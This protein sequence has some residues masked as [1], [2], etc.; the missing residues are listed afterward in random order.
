[1]S[2]AGE[3]WFLGTQG[4]PQLRPRALEVVQASIVAR[5]QLVS[6]FHLFS[7]PDA[8]PSGPSGCLG[9]PQMSATFS[10]RF[11]KPTPFLFRPKSDD[12]RST[13]LFSVSFPLRL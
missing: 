12:V 13:F 6:S 3:G 4:G 1:M 10:P 7:N 2:S 11:Y 9:C 8:Y 5:D